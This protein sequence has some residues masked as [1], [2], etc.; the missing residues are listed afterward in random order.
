MRFQQ[1]PFDGYFH[2][3][4]L[5]RPLQRGD[6]TRNSVFG[7]FTDEGINGNYSTIQIY[8]DLISF[9]RNIQILYFPS[10]FQCS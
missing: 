4:D 2:A 7:D 10:T 3:A 6:H 8:G 5:T 9:N 1:L